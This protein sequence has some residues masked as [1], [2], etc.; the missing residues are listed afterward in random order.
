MKRFFINIFI[1][2]VFLV[3]SDFV[4]GYFSNFLMKNAKGGSTAED[5]YIAN[6]CIE[7]IIIFGS[8]RARHHYDVRVIEDSL[9]L[10]CY[11]M[12]LDGNGVILAY[13]RYK[14]LL[15]RYEPKLIIYDVMPY[16]DY[17]KGEEYI[18]Y[19]T[20][21][22]QYH[23]NMVVSDLA[24]KF[25]DLKENIKM[26]SAMYRNNSSLVNLLVDNI[27]ERDFNSGYIPGYGVMDESEIN[28]ELKMIE[29]DSLKLCLFEDFIADVK[30]RDIPIVVMVSPMYKGV[31]YSDYSI[32][33]RICEK[34]KVPYINY[35]NKENIIN[36]NEYFEN[37]MHM[38]DMGAKIYTK[39][40]VPILRENLN[41]DN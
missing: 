31:D 28:C 38:N 35:L 13:A 3:I 39:D 10:S 15:E 21:L 36:N 8:S 26:K 7:D 4:I 37:R 18:K 17:E 30:N 1:F 41:L 40:I 23:Q 34:Y 19:F 5:Y 20:H 24:D 9:G 25:L 14:M 2:L 32:A 11:N 16:F 27:I 22:K 12:A 29:I 6:E 33:K